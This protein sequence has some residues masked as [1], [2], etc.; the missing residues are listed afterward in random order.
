MRFTLLTACVLAILAAGCS[1]D[2]DAGKVSVPNPP[3]AKP[4]APAETAKPAAPQS[5]GSWLLAPPRPP[6][7][8][9]FPVFLSDGTALAQTL[10]DGTAV[11]LSVHYE[12]VQGQPKSSEKYFWVIEPAKKP[13]GKVPVELQASGT[14]QGFVP[15]KPEDGPFKS[16]LEDA[17]GKRLSQSIDMRP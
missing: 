9:P 4:A 13:A 1:G 16:H 6:E 17:S 5:P 14:L 3:A 2:Y 10:P 7:N 11:G 12:F 15:L 8:H